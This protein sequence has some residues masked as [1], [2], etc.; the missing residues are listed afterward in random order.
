[1]M[2]SLTVL[3]LRTNA[4]NLPSGTSQAPYLPSSLNDL[5]LYSCSSFGQD[6]FDAH[7][8]NDHLPTLKSLDLYSTDVSSLST[9]TSSQRDSITSLV[10]TFGDSQNVVPTMHNLLE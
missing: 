8:G 4:V 2:S 9:L 3:R 10:I 6:A 7:I 1:G 5:D